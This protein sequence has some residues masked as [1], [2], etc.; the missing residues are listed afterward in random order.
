[1]SPVPAVAIGAALAALVLPPDNVIQGKEF[2]GQV[3]EKGSFV[4]R[5]FHIL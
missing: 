1:M 3:L 4:K 5:F 2:Q